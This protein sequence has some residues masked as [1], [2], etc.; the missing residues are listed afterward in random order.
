[1][2]KM[3]KVAKRLPRSR[4]IP[5]TTPQ[6]REAKRLRILEAAAAE[7]AQ[8]GFDTASIE[9]IASRAGIGKGTIYNYTGSKDQLFSECLQLFCDELH[10]LLDETVRTST[11]IARLTTSRPHQRAISRSS[12]ASE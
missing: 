5:S 4:S 8:Y 10:Q 11:H 1:M 3:T 2:A 9:S 6:D 7:F 12:S